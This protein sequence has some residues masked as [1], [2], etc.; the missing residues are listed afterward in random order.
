MFKNLMSDDGPPDP[1]KQ[2]INVK[3]YGAMR[4]VLVKD[5]N[6]LAGLHQVTWQQGTFFVHFY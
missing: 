5:F 1:N 4:R 6:D 2:S 3:L